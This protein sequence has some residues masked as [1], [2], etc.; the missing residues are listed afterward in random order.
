MARS[1]LER[2]AEVSSFPHVYEFD[3]REL[4]SGF[5]LKGNWNKEHFKNDQP[6]VLE[7]GCGKGEYTVGLA[8]KYPGKNF[9]G[10]DIKGNR[11]WRGA[12]TALDE[13]IANAAFLRTRID[14][15]DSCFSMGEVS[16]IWITF[17][18]PQ[19][20]KSRIRK[21]LTSPVFL[22]RYKKI[23]SPGGR[24]RLKTDSQELW[25][26]SL[27]VVREFGHTLICSSPDLYADPSGDFEDAASIETYYESKFKKLGFTICYLEFKLM[28][29]A[30][31][32]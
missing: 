31:K 10:V 18:D 2:F 29:P 27:E 15:I 5:K 17:P 20:Q 21:R 25:N 3:F 12:K 22:A 1:K 13:H 24:I 30:A 6:I 11:I 19:P 26:Y 14:F 28:P 16:E 8:K 32:T 4:D 7:L 23:L 9:I